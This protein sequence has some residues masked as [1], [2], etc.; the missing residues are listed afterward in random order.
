[1][2]PDVRL[3]TRGEGLSQGDGH[4]AG[5]EE[6]RRCLPGTAGDQQAKRSI[7]AQGGARCGTAGTKDGAERGG[8]GFG[9][10]VSSLSHQGQS[11]RD[12]P[13]PKL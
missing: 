13:I 8:W 5:R 2:L 12:C 4:W 3:L 10:G 11:Q 1:M 7:W 9:L 6:S